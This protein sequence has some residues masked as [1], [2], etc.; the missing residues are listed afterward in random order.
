MLRLR[1]ETKVLNI[2]L[3]RMA[4]GDGGIIFLCIEGLSEVKL[5]NS[6]I[7]PI[8]D[9]IKRSKKKAVENQIQSMIHPPRRLVAEHPV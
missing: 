9:T 7:A 1:F 6:Y 3:V 2:V 8:D 5:D 4:S